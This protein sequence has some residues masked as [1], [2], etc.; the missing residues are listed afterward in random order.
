MKSNRLF[1]KVSL[2]KLVLAL[3]GLGLIAVALLTG[4]SNYGQNPQSVSGTDPRNAGTLQATP[5]VRS[6]IDDWTMR[7]LVYRETSDVKVLGRLQQDPRWWIQR[8]AR[9][10]AME[11][12]FDTGGTGL[13]ALLSSPASSTAIN[14]DQKKA[15]HGPNCPVVDWGLSLGGAAAAMTADTYPAKFTFDAFATPDCATD[16]VTMPVN[17]AGVTPAFATGHGTVTG[18]GTGGQTVTVGGQTLTASGSL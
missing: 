4:R 11:S 18:A 10:A 9:R 13:P 6:L 8:L 14:S 17:V 15:C 1:S 12:G 16:Y 2:P 5:E 7:H 3:V